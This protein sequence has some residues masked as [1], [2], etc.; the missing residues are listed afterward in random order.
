MSIT[1]IMYHD[2]VADGQFDSSGF[3][4]NGAELYK[5]GIAEFLRQLEGMARLPNCTPRLVTETGK[6]PTYITFDDGGRGAITHAASALEALGWRGHFFVATDFIDTPGF[7]LRAE[8]RELHD[9]GHLIGSH[10]A[11]HPLR[12]GAAD[13]ARLEYEWMRSTDVLSEVLAAPITVA[14]VP[15]GMFTDAVAVAAEK[16]GIRH[17]FTSEPVSTSWAIGNCR[18][19]G[20]YTIVSRTTTAEAVALVRGDRMPRYRQYAL[21]NAKKLVKRIGGESYLSLRR[22]V[23]E[24][25]S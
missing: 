8:I 19:Y 20:R 9:R 5:L 1:T 18:M 2:I 3:V 23:L 13:M 17:L 11:S 14:S 10:S 25:R 4:G 7:L 12:M 15:G 16:S 21:W 24:R 6:E 22:R